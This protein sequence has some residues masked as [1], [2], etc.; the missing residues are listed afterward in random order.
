MLQ[1]STYLVE[2]TSNSKSDVCN[3]LFYYIWW[4]A[5]NDADFFFSAKDCIAEPNKQIRM[6]KLYNV[7]K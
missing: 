7:L 3:S 6:E 5:L 2:H 4:W 1:A